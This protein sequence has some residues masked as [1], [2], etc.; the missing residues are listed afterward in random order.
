[1]YQRSKEVRSVTLRVV[2]VGVFA[3]TEGGGGCNHLIIRV[4]HNTITIKTV[5]LRRT[6]VNGKQ[7][8]GH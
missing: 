3:Q 6:Q 1:M 2:F 4:L 8:L 7:G 5:L